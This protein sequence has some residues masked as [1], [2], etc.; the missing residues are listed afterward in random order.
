MSLNSGNNP[1]IVKTAIDTVFMSRFDRE[2][3]PGEVL[4]TDGMFFRQE[5]TSKAA[6]ITEEYL[7]PSLFTIND[8]EEE[9]EGTTPRTDN[10]ITHTVNKYAEK[11]FI[12]DV[13]F[14]D[15]QHNIV[16]RSIQE[17]GRKARLT[18]DAFA[19]RQTY[20]DAFSGATT[21][22]GVALISNSHVALSGDTIDN[23]ETGTLTPDNLK[24]LFV[25]LTLQK[26]Q[27]GD[28]GAHNAKGLLVPRVL[29]DEAMEITKSEL[30]ANTAE[31]NLNYF[32]TVYPGLRVGSSAF[33]DSAFNSLNTNADTSFFILAQ[34][35]GITRWVRRGLK[36]TLVS[37]D[38]DVR[39]RWL[40]KASFREIVAPITWEGIVGS[41]GTV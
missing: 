34:D 2:Q 23:L 4:A 30:A 22:D 17:F 28:L 9:L 29:H 35:H 38:T 7:P 32:S 8:E 36:T 25:S 39:D 21:S 15:D 40:Y 37:P 19:F 13:F 10:Q 12:S 14:E 31:N 20:G 33:L 18:R 6:E 27:A 5:E 24:T 26:D 41:N 11:M 3:E 16:D 1:S